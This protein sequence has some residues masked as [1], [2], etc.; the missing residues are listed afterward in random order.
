M[1]ATVFAAC[2]AMFL[3]ARLAAAQETIFIQPPHFDR[4]RLA[5]EGANTFTAEQISKALGTDL[6]LAI[7]NVKHLPPGDQPRLLVEKTI[8]GYR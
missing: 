1:R 5:I 2:G 6:D 8:A 4:S 7:A 3:L